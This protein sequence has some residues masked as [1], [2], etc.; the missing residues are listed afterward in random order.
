MSAKT[1]EILVKANKTDPVSQRILVR[2][3]EYYHPQLFRWFALP[4]QWEA[5]A[6]KALAAA[7]K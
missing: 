3:G 2:D 7:D 6:K 4:K 1:A 5:Q